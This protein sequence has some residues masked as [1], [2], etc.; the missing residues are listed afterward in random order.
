[1]EVQDCVWKYVAQC[2]TYCACSTNATFHLSD[3]KFHTFLAV[4]KEDAPP[5]L[6]HLYSKLRKELG[7]LHPSPR[8]WIPSLLSSVHPSIHPTYIFIYSFIHWLICYLPNYITFFF[9][10]LIFSV[11]SLN[12]FKKWL[13]AW[14]D[15][16][17]QSLGLPIITR[18]FGCYYALPVQSCSFLKMSEE[19]DNIPMDISVFYTY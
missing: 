9:L 18:M 3:A 19:T 2:M 14:K 17:F 10:W 13:W 16:Y 15:S 7:L 11:K 4:P 12:V 1:M 6:H 5:L 8:S